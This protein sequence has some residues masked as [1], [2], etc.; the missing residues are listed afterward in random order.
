MDHDD[1][2]GGAGTGIGP[3]ACANNQTLGHCAPGYCC[4]TDNKCIPWCRVGFNADCSD[5]STCQNFSTPPV[6]G[7]VTYGLCE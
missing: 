1:C 4:T 7:G 5:G 6:I 2:F 3:D